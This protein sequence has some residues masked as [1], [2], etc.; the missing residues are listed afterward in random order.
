MH[1]N[2]DPTVLASVYAK[3]RLFLRIHKSGK[4]PQL[5]TCTIAKAFSHLDFYP[6]KMVAQKLLQCDY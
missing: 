6:Y 2:S 5:R 1:R 3:I 4:E